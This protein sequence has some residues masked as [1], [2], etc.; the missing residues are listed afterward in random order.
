VQRE[1]VETVEKKP[2]ITDSDN[3]TRKSGIETHRKVMG[4]EAK[5]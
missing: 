4:R 2:A 1:K 5:V 3:K